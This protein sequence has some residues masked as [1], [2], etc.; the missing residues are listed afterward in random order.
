MS[1]WSSSAR[2]L[3]SENRVAAFSPQRD[4][5]AWDR[6]NLALGRYFLQAKANLLFNHLEASLASASGHG[7]DVQGHAAADMAA[8]EAAA[9]GKARLGTALRVGD[10]PARSSGELTS[11]ADRGNDVAYRSRKAK[12][13]NAIWSVLHAVGAKDVAAFKRANQPTEEQ[14][15]MVEKLRSLMESGCGRQGAGKSEQQREM[16]RLKKSVVRFL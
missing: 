3:W 1:S 5:W 2:V 7:H 8:F 14:R 10:G 12:H 6:S 16:R 15:E 9:E 4:V 13:H 11:A